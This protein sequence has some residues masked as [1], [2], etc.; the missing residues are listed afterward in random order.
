VNVYAFLD[1]LNFFHAFFLLPDRF[2]VSGNGFRDSRNDFRASR[3]DFRASGCGF[4]DSGNDFRASGK[5]LRKAPE[6]CG[7]LSIIKY[8]QLKIKRR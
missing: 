1:D 4:R 3:N 7:N 8:K 2:R 5:G 6:T